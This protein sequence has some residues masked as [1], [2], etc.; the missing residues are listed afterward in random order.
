[1]NKP[2]KYTLEVKDG[3]ARAGVIE[4]WENRNACIYAS[5]NASDSKSNDK[6]GVR[7]D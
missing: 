5:W 7:G 6:R 1:M 2:I 4:T 3:N